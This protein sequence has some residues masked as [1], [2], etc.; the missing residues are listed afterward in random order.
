[1]SKMLWQSENMHYPRKTQYPL[2]LGSP[3]YSADMG[4]L[5]QTSKWSGSLVWRESFPNPSSS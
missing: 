5:V 4:Q 3:C 1:L 2:I